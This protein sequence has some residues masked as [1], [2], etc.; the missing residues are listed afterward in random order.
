MTPASLD[1]ETLYAQ[2]AETERDRKMRTAF[3]LRTQGLSFRKIAAMVGVSK[4]TVRQWII[5]EEAA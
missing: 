4:D 3:T 1:W 2:F 5:N